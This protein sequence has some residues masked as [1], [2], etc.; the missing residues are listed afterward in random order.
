MFAIQE[1]YNLNLYHTK[2]HAADVMQA[3]FFY[4]ECCEGRDQMQLTDFEVL[5]A[6]IA[7]GCHD[8]HH[9]GNK[10]DFEA[11]LSTTLAVIYN[12]QS[13]LEN[14][15]IAVTFSVLKD[16]RYNIMETFTAD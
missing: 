5:T 11:K 7:A 8:V 15:H 6:L 12:D 14:Y 4:L 9:P 16:E 2:V 10:N 3:T 13:I 1:L